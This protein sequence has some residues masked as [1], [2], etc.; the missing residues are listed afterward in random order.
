MYSLFPALIIFIF[1]IICYGVGRVVI[2]GFTFGQFR[3]EPFHSSEDFGWFGR[4]RR[5]DR[6][7]VLSA[8]FTTILGL[9]V[10]A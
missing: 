1:K 9:I 2:T 7:Y 4:Y 10:L 5:L 8:L 6:T 3:C